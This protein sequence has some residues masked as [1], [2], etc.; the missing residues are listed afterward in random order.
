MVVQR[1]IFDNK[2]IIWTGCGEEK[3]YALAQEGRDADLWILIWEELHRVHREGL[4]VE[5]EHVKAHRCKK[6]MQQVSLCEKFITEGSENADEP[7]K[8]GAMLDGGD[9]AQSSAITVQQEREEFDAALQDAAAFH[10]LVEE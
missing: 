5:V 3:C 9:M 2:G 10:C 6:E 4:L 7:A 8:E 1:C